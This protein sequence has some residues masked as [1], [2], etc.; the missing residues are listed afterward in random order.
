[1]QQ[2][3]YHSKTPVLNHTAET[4]YANINTSHEEDDLFQLVMEMKFKRVDLIERHHNSGGQILV[5]Q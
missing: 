4:L 5:K 3:K 2:I 1:M